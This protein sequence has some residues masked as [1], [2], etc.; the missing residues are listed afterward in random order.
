MHD[1]EWLLMTNL[2]L[3]LNKAICE[4]VLREV[5]LR[6]HDIQIWT[7]WPRGGGLGSWS[8]ARWE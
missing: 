4:P 8:K 3:R 7:M 5:A 1:Y 6:D 2:G